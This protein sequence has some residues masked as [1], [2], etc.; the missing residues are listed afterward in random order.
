ME[1]KDDQ[2]QRLSARADR[3]RHS[4]DPYR[5]RPTRLLDAEL[6]TLYGVTTKR[7]D[8]Q[9]KRNAERFPGDFMFQLSPDESGVLRSHSAH[10]M[11]SPNMARSWPQ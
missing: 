11:P 2:P 9:V 3:A 7:F 4:L 1:A 10:R 5:A 6:A 8:E